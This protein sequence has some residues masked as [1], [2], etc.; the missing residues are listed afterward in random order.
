MNF[1]SIYKDKLIAL[2]EEARQ[3]RNWALADD[4]RDYL[5]SEHIFVFD[6]PTQQVVYHRKSGSRRDLIKQ[7]KNE[8]RAQNQF[9]AWLYSLNTSMNHK[10]RKNVSI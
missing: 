8:Q 2:R 10:N 4:I 9:E 3:E 6:T 7:I 5:D 1:E